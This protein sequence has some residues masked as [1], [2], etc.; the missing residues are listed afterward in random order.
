[1]RLKHTFV[2]AAMAA[3]TMAAHAT[4]TDWAVHG[5]IE[6][7]IGSVPTGSIND[8]FSFKL[9]NPGVLYASAVANNL[10]ATFD[11]TDGLVSL[12]RLGVGGEEVLNSFSFNGTT[13]N[14]TTNF[15]VQGIGDYA[16]RVTGTATGS[17]GGVYS[18]TSE[19]A[20]VTPVPEPDGLA[21]T[22]AGIAALAFLQRR[23]GQ[24][25]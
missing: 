3:A 7:G 4:N 6:V 19:V 17:M 1:M 9:A 25:R 22:T 2:M 15:G 21:L 12:V 13:G 14:L 18:I 11:I 16:Y 5:P 20:P 10:N 23:R 24:R 8:T